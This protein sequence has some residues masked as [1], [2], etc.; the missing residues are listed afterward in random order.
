MGI[1]AKIRKKFKRGKA[2]KLPVGGPS[3][4]DKSTDSSS[5][6]MGDPF[7]GQYSFLE[8]VLGQSAGI[9]GSLGMSQEQRYQRYL[10]M[11]QQQ[12]ASISQLQQ[13]MSMAAAATPSLGMCQPSRQPVCSCE[14]RKKHVESRVIENITGDKAK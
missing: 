9:P 14:V 4:L 8:A 5:N 12:M 3:H 2:M 10:S 6:T 7:A 1:L 11:A 13:A